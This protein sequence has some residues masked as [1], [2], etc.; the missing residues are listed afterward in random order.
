MES[1]GKSDSYA[2]NSQTCAYVASK[3]DLESWHGTG[4]YHSITVSGI[5]AGTVEGAES[6]AYS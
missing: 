4:C 5:V 2:G 6:V 3:S 1:R